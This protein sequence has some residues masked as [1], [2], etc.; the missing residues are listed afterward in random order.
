VLTVFPC[1]AR[2][3]CQVAR[4]LAEFLE[5]GASVQIFLEDGEIGPGETLVSKAADGLQAAVILLILSPDSAPSLGA[6]RYWEPVLLD[7][8]RRE[9]VKVAMVLARS[10]E[11]PALLR[12][13]AFFDLTTDRLA[14]F[15][16]IKRWLVALEPGSRQFEF[17]PARQSCVDGCDAEMEKLR[18]SIADAPGTAILTGAGKTTLA[19]EFARQSK[20]DFEGLVW[21]TCTEQT[22]ASLAGDMASQLGMSLEGDVEENLIQLGKFCSQRRL[23]IV[24][25]DASGEAA[26]LAAPGR[27][28]T[29]VVKR[30]AGPRPATGGSRGA[31]FRAGHVGIYADVSRPAMQIPAAV[32]AC[33]N[34][35]FRPALIAEIASLDFSAASALLEELV[36]GGAAI[37]LDVRYPRYVVQSAA[38]HMSLARAHAQAI[39]RLFAHW[40]KDDSECEA[41]LPQ[42]RRALNWALQDDESWGLACDLAK[43][44]VALLKSKRRQAEVFEM[45]KT[46]LPEAERREDRRTLEDCSREQ[47]WILESWGRDEEAEMIRRT[48]CAPYADQMQFNFDPVQ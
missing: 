4:D 37:Q 25:D 6:R 46:V 48:H 43:R 26:R 5:R 20:R 36:A 44:A 16:E 27:S 31:G 10:C 17:E 12:R 3:D 2:E 11:F 30:G 29:L 18:Q 47:V 35:P 8:P 13:D 42:L 40:A 22:L 23:L 28:S 38:P 39:C 15:R 24:L 19:L 34:V 41:D 14:A 9:G 45:L 7:Q 1:F 21:L 33:G 32:H